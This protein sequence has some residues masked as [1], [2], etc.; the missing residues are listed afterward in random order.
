MIKKASILILLISF[1]VI[2]SG[3]NINKITDDN[4]VFDIDQLLDYDKQFECEEINVCND[5]SAKTYMDYRMT[6]VR[7]SK[8]YQFIH[9]SLSVDKKT[10]FLYDKD[11]FIAVALGSYYGQ[12]GDRYYFTLD[13]GIVLP[14]VKAEEKADV[15]TDGSGC[16]HLVDSSVIEFVIDTDYALDYFYHGN[17][18]VLNGNYNNYS[19]FNGKIKKVEKVSDIKKDKIVTYEFYNSKPQS[20]EIFD[21][22][23]GY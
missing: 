10:G 23:F 9:S 20:I 6:T 17:G 1:I 18:L 13:S 2:L 3:F 22:A 21:Y 15:D 8:Q 14:L 5:S 11:G 19:L 12:I 16:Y 4:Y 7:S